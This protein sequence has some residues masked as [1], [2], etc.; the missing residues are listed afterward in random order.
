MNSEGLA[1]FFLPRG[2]GETKHFA[3]RESLPTSFCDKNALLGCSANRARRS[4]NPIAV[5]STCVCNQ[6][7]PV[8]SILR[9]I[10]DNAGMCKLFSSSKTKGRWSRY[11]CHFRSGDTPYFRC[12]CRLFCVLFCRKLRHERLLTEPLKRLEFRALQGKNKNMELSKA[13]PDFSGKLYWSAHSA[14]IQ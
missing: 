4:A 3:S 2:R 10:R 11:C 7:Q 12:F 13:R 6:T 9:T 5:V 14:V 1:Y 8:R